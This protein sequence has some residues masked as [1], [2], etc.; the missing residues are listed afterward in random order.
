M[1]SQKESSSQKGNTFGS[2]FQPKIQRLWSFKTIEDGDSSDRPVDL[3]SY[4]LGEHFRMAKN[5]PR[6]WL[7]NLIT[8]WLLQMSAFRIS[9]T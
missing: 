9:T 5:L 3:E 6:E 1:A 4:D 8:I 7:S 2:W